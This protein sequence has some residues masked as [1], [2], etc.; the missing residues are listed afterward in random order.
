V[1]AETPNNNPHYLEHYPGAVED[2]ID[3][4]ELAYRTKDI[5]NERARLLGA[6]CIITEIYD[7][8]TDDKLRTALHKREKALRLSWLKDYGL[9]SMWHHS[10]LIYEEIDEYSDT[11]VYASSNLPSDYFEGSPE[12]ENL[13]TAQEIKVDGQHQ[14]AMLSIK[15]LERITAFVRGRVAEIEEELAQVHGAGI[16]EEEHAK[17]VAEDAQFDPAFQESLR[18]EAKW[19]S[20]AASNPQKKRI[21]LSRAA[22]EKARREAG[23]LT[24]EP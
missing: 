23:N 5:E 22:T 15:G 12:L 10:G 4:R 6:L 7:S 9:N 16:T 17:L 19:R 3:A 1:L 21:F 14:L 11:W 2:F 18:K 20:K 13:R 24:S 8:G